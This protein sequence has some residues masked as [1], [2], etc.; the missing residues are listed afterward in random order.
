MITA[1]KLLN[2]L[3]KDIENGKLT[4]QDEV[5]V[6]FNNLCNTFNIDLSDEQK[7]IFILSF[8]DKYLP[9]QE[10]IDSKEDDLLDDFL[11][12]PEDEIE[13]LLNK[14]EAYKAKI[15]ENPEKKISIQSMISKLRKK[16]RD[17]GYEFETTTRTKTDKKSIESLKA[18]LEQL[19]LD[20]ALSPMQKRKS[21]QS[22]ISKIKR[23]LR[24]LDDTEYIKQP[25]EKVE[26]IKL[27]PAE[28]IGLDANDYSN[29]LNNICETVDENTPFNK[30]IIAGLINYSRKND[31]DLQALAKYTLREEKNI[32]S[33]TLFP[34]L[35]YTIIPT[36]IQDQALKNLAKLQ[37]S[38]YS[39]S[40]ADIQVANNLCMQYNIDFD[41]EKLFKKIA[42]CQ[43]IND[44]KL[45]LNSLD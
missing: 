2:I 38:K 10:E 35:N 24:D 29:Y 20:L 8:C 13:K 9:E 14:I 22:M 33:E 4:T 28:K 6:R 31:I 30:L 19:E 12:T 7:D 34:T 27:T 26:K 21:V 11:E 37:K 16:L 25:K 40:I 36:L 1:E 32:F 45:I 39:L 42:K 5:Y 3:L 15:I 18:K 17:L 43:S 41:N 23:Q 44:V